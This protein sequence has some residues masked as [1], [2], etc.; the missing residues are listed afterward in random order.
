MTN[1]ILS[2]NNDL[3]SLDYSAL[4]EQILQTLQANSQQSEPI[5][6]SSQDGKRLLINVDKIAYQLAEKEIESPL[7]IGENRAK[8]ATINLTKAAKPRFIQK[9]KLIRDFLQESLENILKNDKTS[10]LE[11][12]IQTLIKPLTEFQGNSGNQL[13]LT[14]PF[15]I[16]YTGLEKQR[17]MVSK[18]NYQQ[19]ALLRFHRLTISIDGL[20][21]FKEGLKQSLENY[22]NLQFLDESKENQG[23]L[24]YIL[25]ELVN[26]QS[27]QSDFYRL[28]KL[29]NEEALGK[30]QR[31]AKI[32]YL[33]FLKEHINQHHTLAYLED[34][35]RR[36]R[37]LES[38][39][40]DPN[41]GDGD[42]E[43]N[44]AGET[45][46]YRELFNRAD[47]FDSL[48]I[49][50]LIAGYLGE[51]QNE[52]EGRKDCIFGLK[53][54]LAGA[55]QAADG[56]S[57]FD[58]HLNLLDWESQAHQDGL[59][60]ELRKKFFVEKVLRVALLYYFVFASRKA[61]QADLDYNPII[62]WESDILPI[63][64]GSD[65]DRKQTI[66]QK[67]KEGLYKYNV[68][69]KIEK[70][71]TLLTDFLKRKSTFSSRSYPVA[72]SVS[73]TI[74][75][76]DY[77][78]IDDSNSFFKEELR[79]N[80]KNALKYL[81]IGESTINPD[82]LYSL[83]IT[84]TID[85]L[86]Y[87]S[88]GETQ[89]FS[90]EYDTRRIKT[91]PILVFGNDQCC[92]NTYN[93][94]I[95]ENNLIIFPYNHQRLRESIYSESASSKRFIY[96]VT[97]ALLVYIILSMIADA[98]PKS[99]FLPIIRFHLKSKDAT[100]EK[101]FR[102]ILYVITHLLNE[103]NRSSCQ[104]F[105]ILGLNPF[106]IKNGLASLYGNVP[107][108]FRFKNDSFIPKLEKL[109]II[110]VSSRECDR[111]YRSDD[112]IAN[113]FGEVVGIYRQ[114]DHSI[115][116]YTKGTFSGNYQGEDIY[117]YPTVLIDEVNDLYSKG[118]RHFLYIAKSPYTSTLNL[119]QTD[120]DKELYFMSS[121]IIRTLKANRADLKIYPIFFDKYYTVPFQKQVS[122]LYIQDT[123]ELSEIV[124]DPHKKSVV[125]F[126]LFNGRS[127]G[128]DKYYRGVISYTTLLNFYEGILD[129]T[130]I[131]VGLIN[132]GELKRDLLQYLTLYHFSRYEKTPTQ[133]DKISL[134]LD[135]YQGI[136]GDESLGKLAIFPHINPKIK[137]NLLAFLTEV[138]RCLNTKP[139][140][141][142]E[143]V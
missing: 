108:I 65:E 26:D 52:T 98:Y 11:S 67:F 96:Q 80:P 61:D 133:T 88:T 58:Y 17:L 51:I 32:C 87:Y 126:N 30:L 40:N 12:Y 75:E 136:I 9:V 110:V 134:K 115:R 64:Q 107:K 102:S 48:P 119:T 123:V 104:G 37:L 19:S 31:E 142:E 101:S 114:D 129:D 59:E 130:D 137:F 39:I 105:N 128:N 41:K 5:F 131:H 23:D 138:R 56:Q 92:W 74:L 54:K 29:L 7:G 36:L 77:Q 82:A 47:G 85:D 79:N 68:S 95:K 103:E 38:Y 89:S 132:E 139:E 14:Y 46:N 140:T 72:L 16:P 127:V 99:L 78:T 121:S 21:H 113:I 35:I 42:Y 4:L 27:Q 111:T 20:N 135:P 116:L 100:E 62:R 90:M 109:A 3:V 71:K 44:Y 22:I 15:D 33:E 76:E 122:S 10:S 34:L 25:E 106:K 94:Q 112:K 63:L 60:D 13:S 1:R 24:H 66:L 50:P 86:H 118:Y 91:I 141:P 57:S 93:K 8:T 69:N 55:V 49:I 97:F 73:Q 120:E 45:V 43:V 70:L 125:F 28:I 6:K 18:N 117:T 2:S 53:L 83:N 84:I 143:E 81:S 124:R